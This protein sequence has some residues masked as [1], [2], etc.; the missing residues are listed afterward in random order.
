MTVF[1]LI[2]VGLAAW[3]LINSYRQHVAWAE[4]TTHNLALVIERYLVG[5]VR[6][7]EMVLLSVKDEVERTDV[8]IE[9]QDIESEVRNQFARMGTLD[10]LRT[11]GRDGRIEHHAGDD[12]GL[13][14][15]FS[16]HP[17]FQQLRQTPQTGLYMSPPTKDGT[18][19]HWVITLAL[20]MERPAG[21]FHGVVSATIRLDQFTRELAQVEVGRLG[22]I[23]V[24]GGNLELLARYPGFPGQD[25]AI[26]DTRIS[27]DYLAAVQSGRQASH[28]TT[29]SRLDGQVRTYTF[30]RLKDP[31]FFVLV[32]LAEKDYLSPWRREAVLSG[33]AILGLLTLS[34]GFAW[35]ARTTWRRQMEAQAERDCLISELTLALA[36]VKSLKGLLPICGHCKKIRDDRGYWNHL[37]SYISAHTDATFTHGLCPDC[38]GEFRQEIKARHG[39]QDKG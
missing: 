5:N 12:P 22:S 26:G 28:F 11:I 7:V 9:N 38:A 1:N 23:S 33:V 2:V 20:R 15:D 25:E 21:V 10:S 13:G 18:S 34:L 35:M 8:A 27:G 17:F 3:T 24:R 39:D 37:E 31:A 14:I 29:T 6:Q 16:Q 36:E 30:R 19:G 32:G 4:G